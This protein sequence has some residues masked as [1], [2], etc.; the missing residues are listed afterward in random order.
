[1]QHPETIEHLN[2]K[3]WNRSTQTDARERIHSHL[4][5]KIDAYIHDDDDDGKKENKKWTK[6]KVKNGMKR[7]THQYKMYIQGDDTVLVNLWA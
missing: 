6:K 5:R 1:M 3:K 4:H 7:L 2:C